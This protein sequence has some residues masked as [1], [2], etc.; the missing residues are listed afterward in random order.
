[1]TVLKECLL[2]FKTFQGLLLLIS[3]RKVVMGLTLTP[4]T[5]PSRPKLFYPSYYQEYVTYG[6]SANAMLSVPTVL[7]IHHWCLSR[8]K[9]GFFHHGVTLMFLINNYH[10]LPIRD[11]SPMR[12]V[13]S[14]T[15]LK[16]I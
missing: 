2:D 14:W 8:S 6:Y 13:R 1:M 7:L 3:L 5:F 4:P 11:H 16:A 9:S 12:F 15:R 10:S